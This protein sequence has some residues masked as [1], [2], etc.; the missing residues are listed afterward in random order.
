MPRVAIEW[1]TCNG[2][3]ERRTDHVKCVR[4]GDSTVV[5]SNTRKHTTGTTTGTARASGGNTRITF[6]IFHTFV[7]Q[8]QNS[9]TETHEQ[10]DQGVSLIPL[11]DYP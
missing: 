1:R 9:Q 6:T 3:G 8:K 11:L 10:C 2:H 5:M 7:S 4:R